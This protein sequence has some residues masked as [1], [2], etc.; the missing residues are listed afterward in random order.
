MPPAPGKRRKWFWL[1]LLVGITIGAGYAWQRHQAGVPRGEE[2][3]RSGKTG[4]GRYMAVAAQPVSVQVVQQRDVR[5]LVNAIGNIA[6]GNTA[7][8][9]TQVDGVLQALHFKEGQ[10]VRAGQGLAQIDPQPFQ[11]ALVQAQGTLARD[12]ALLRNAQ[13]DLKRY[14]DLLAKDAAPAQQV[15]TQ[16]ALVQQLQ[17]SVLADQA[18]VDNAKLQ[19]SYTHVVAPI[20]GLA[21]LKQA[22]LGNNVHTS[23]TNGLLSITQ[24]QPVNVVFAVPES[25]LPRIRKQ[26]QAHAT[27]RVEAWDQDQKTLLAV[28]KVASTDNAIDPTTGTIRIKALFPNKDNSLF[29]NQFVNVK[30]QLDT[31]PGALAVS[32]A[33]VQRGAPGT[34]VY[35]V[36]G[37]SMVSLRR[38]TVGAV[39]GD[40]TAVQGELKAGERVVVDGADRLRDGAKVQVIDATKAA[41]AA[42]QATSHKHGASGAQAA[43]S[44]ERPRWMDRVPPDMQ[45][46]LKAMS[47]EDRKAWFQKQRSQ[48]N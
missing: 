28:G 3:G 12:Q 8:V 29:P 22:D 32:S 46:K 14:R 13:L 39:D 23:D 17:G 44:G 38:V 26:L 10:P 41:S 7:V 15:D 36:D 25:R 19:L 21:G 5:V 18:G 35:V 9:H 47:P 34:Y 20:S 31:L 27:L 4:S 24:T 33:A 43:A 6:A 30:L 40:W 37:D 42:T 48:G 11:I 16:E 1:L 2:T 45:D